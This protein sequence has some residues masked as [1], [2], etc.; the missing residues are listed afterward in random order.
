[1]RG[2]RVRGEKERETESLTFGARRTFTFFSLF[3]LFGA[4]RSLYS[5]DYETD[6]ERLCARALLVTTASP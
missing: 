2:K 5:V 1:M 6:I 4:G 3:A